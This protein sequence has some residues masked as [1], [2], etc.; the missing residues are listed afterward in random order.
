MECWIADCY[1]E[2]E[3]GSH[4]CSVHCWTATTARPQPARTGA[5]MRRRGEAQAEVAAMLADRCRTLTEVA[6]GLEVDNGSAFKVLAALVRDGR[7]RKVSLGVY[8]AV[9]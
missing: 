2:R 5:S 9:R 7:A 3:P 4:L 8:E 6:R 1:R